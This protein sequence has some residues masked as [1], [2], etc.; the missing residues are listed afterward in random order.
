MPTPTTL[1]T[2]KQY[3]TIPEICLQFTI[4]YSQLIITHGV[5]HEDTPLIHQ[6]RYKVQAYVSDMY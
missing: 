2:R 1:S 4:A 6:A 5:C 3:A